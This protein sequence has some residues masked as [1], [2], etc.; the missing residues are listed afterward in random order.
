MAFQQYFC[1]PLQISD[2]NLQLHNPSWNKVITTIVS[3]PLGVNIE[4][5]IKNDMLLVLHLCAFNRFRTITTDGEKLS[6][7]Q[8]MQTYMANYKPK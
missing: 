2:T 3:A 6:V 4:E 8:T 7:L 5:L 1:H